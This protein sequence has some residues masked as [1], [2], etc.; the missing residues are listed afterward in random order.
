[1]STITSILESSQCCSLRASWFSRR[2]VYALSPS[3]FWTT[4]AIEPF[5][6]VISPI[7]P[8]RCSTVPTSPGVVMDG[9][10]MRII[11]FGPGGLLLIGLSVSTAIRNLSIA[12]V[13]GQS[14]IPGLWAQR[15]L[16]GTNFLVFWFRQRYR[17]FLC[18]RYLYF[19]AVEKRFC[20]FNWKSLK[21]VDFWPCAPWLLNSYFHSNLSLVSWF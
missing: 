17:P 7:G 14:E 6:K 20:L 13:R 18:C 12:D 10:V 2:E 15:D 4:S 11:L 19:K 5:L 9:K 21:T 3:H 1:M 16:H 8:M